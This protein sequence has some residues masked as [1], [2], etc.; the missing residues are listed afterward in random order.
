METINRLLKK[1]TR[2]RNKRSTVATPEDRTPGANDEE[3]AEPIPETPPPPPSCY[4]WTSS[5]AEVDG[6][7]IMQLSFSVPISIVPSP[8]TATGE[9]DAMV[10]DV[11]PIV[12]VPPDTSQSHRDVQS[13]KCDLEGCGRLRK[14]RLV[15]DWKKGA[16]GMEHLKALQ[17]AG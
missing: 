15:S 3:V 14:Y 4:R 8:S 11:D 9:G 2:T 7:K 1:Q 12:K 17:A 16:C 10:M 6:K 13:P 5:S